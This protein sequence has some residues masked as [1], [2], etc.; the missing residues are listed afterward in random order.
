MNKLELLKLKK[1]LLMATITLTTAL[2]Y[3]YIDNISVKADSNYET[4]TEDETNETIIESK[5][6]YYANVF[7]LNE[8][9]VL[10]YFKD[11][12]RNFT[13][14]EWEH[15]ACINNKAYDNKEVA[16]IYNIYDLRYNPQNYG[17]TKEELKGDN[18]YTTKAE[19]EE[20]IEKYSN[21]IGIN[22][23]I[24][25]AIC[26]T[27][28]GIRPDSYNFLERNNPGGLG[29]MYF[30]NREMGMIVFIIILK[31]NYGCT[32]E[33]D[34]SFFTRSAHRY[35]PPNPEHW[36][37]MANSIYYSLDQDYY[38]Y[39]PDVADKIKDR[40]VLERNKGAK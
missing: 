18:S 25:M 11:K 39:A 23:K 30:E 36:R 34:T 15:H 28:C 40:K 31:E 32:K 35:C 14:Y 33:S 24:P 21:I 2:S 7:N 5:I 3:G 1:K 12:T 37:G 17:Y 19:P 20:L 29:S 13:S 4:T 22:K 38:F 8:D 10:D 16:I 6:K 9:I 27:E 26:Y